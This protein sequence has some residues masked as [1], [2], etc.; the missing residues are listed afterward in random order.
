[1]LTDMH[2]FHAVVHDIAAVTSSTK[3]NKKYHSH[4]QVMSQ[5]NVML[6]SVHWYKYPHKFN[7]ICRKQVARS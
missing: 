5:E 6:V 2:Q 7:Y 3:I 4:A 1:M